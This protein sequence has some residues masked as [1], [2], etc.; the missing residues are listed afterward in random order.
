MPLTWITNTLSGLTIGVM[1]I[2]AS[3]SMAA[4]VFSGELAAHLSYGVNIALV[5][6]VITGAILAFSSSCK[7]AISIPQD[8]TAPVLAFMAT[9]IASMAPADMPPDQIFITV[10]TAIVAT[11]LITGAF[12]FSLGLARAGGLM[13]FIPYSVLGGFLAG[14]GWLLVIG[15]L[16]A[17]SGLDLATLGG[18]RD[19]LD[20]ES[21][22]YWLPGLALAI[23]IILASR[24]MVSGVAFISMLVVGTTLF[25]GVML[26]NGETLDSLGVSG[27]LVGPLQSDGFGLWELGLPR[28]I[29]SGDWAMVFSQWPNIGTV[30]AITAISIMLTVSALEI[31]SGRD[32][33]IN[34][35]LR[36][37]GMAN[38]AA[39]VGGGMVGFHSLSISN[40]SL[41]LGANSRLTGIVAAI[42]TAL[43]LYLGTEIIGFLPRFVIGGLLLY[44][45]ITFVAKW[46]FGSWGRLPHGEFLLI[47]LITVT[48][49][50]V[51][52]IEGLFLGLLAA[53]IQ[54]VLKYSRTAVIRYALSGTS[55]QSAVER[56]I[57]EER[58][59]A[60]HGERTLI[61]KLRGYLFF[62]TTAQ[63]STQIR[64]RLEDEPRPPLGYAVLDFAAVNGIDSSATYEFH[65]LQ[66]MAEQNNFVLLLTG[67]S[68]A[69]LQQLQAAHAFETSEHV[70]VFDDLDHGLEWCEEQLLAERLQTGSKE[71]KTALTLMAQRFDDDSSIQAFIGYLSE[72]P[73]ESGDR[74]IKQGEAATDLFFLEEGDV[75]VYLEKP[76]GERNRIRHTGPG[77]VLGELG[78]YL[79]AP[80]T[81]SVIAESSGTAYRLTSEALQRMQNEYPQLASAF[82]HFMADLMAERLLRTTRALE[83]ALG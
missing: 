19:L 34:H 45:G 16:R 55:T 61:L 72:V 43:A 78:F 73:F 21:L 65:R 52:F 60:E 23:A 36:V 39:G 20:P 8:R 14:T 80:R 58:Y 76:N 11:S 49:A 31:L 6:A 42:T 59:L 13:R 53:L 48:I 64:A 5:T 9:G 24:F 27:W 83:G 77:T 17:M 26:G 44:L 81:A 41:Q 66:L 33:D 2:I 69:L 79:E 10:A 62:G 18:I 57:E 30:V 15:G 35:E 37:T 51:G 56:S 1:S 68:D 74:L 7:I 67:L 12:L 54:F 82:H 70:R 4:L 3:V 38:L 71:P 75:S 46:L 50:A 25:F 29:A 32:I 40:L 22:R 63:L 28:L 47:P